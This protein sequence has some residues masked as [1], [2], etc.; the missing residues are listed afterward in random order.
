VANAGA[1]CLKK[2]IDITFCLQTMRWITSQVTALWNMSEIKQ[3]PDASPLPGL[4]PNNLQ[5][6]MFTHSW[7][8][9]EHIYAMAKPG[10][11]VGVNYPQFNPYGKY[12]V[13]LY[14]MVCTLINVNVKIFQFQFQSTK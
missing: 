12:V 9:W 1:F 5:E 2:I 8:P 4:D 7:R 13:K 3:P 10:K 11:G 6:T 14:W